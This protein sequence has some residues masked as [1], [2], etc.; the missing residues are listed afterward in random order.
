[1]TLPAPLTLKAQ[2]KLPLKGVAL[3]DG[4]KM[5]KVAYKKDQRATWS[6]FFSSE[7]DDKVVATARAWCKARDFRFIAVEPAIIS[8]DDVGS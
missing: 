1:M 8:L 4:R 5:F 3:P 6:L 7:E 2:I